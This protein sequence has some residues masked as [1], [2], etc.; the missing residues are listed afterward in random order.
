MLYSLSEQFLP[1]SG[2]SEDETSCLSLPSAPPPSRQRSTADEVH[3][4]RR[5]LRFLLCVLALGFAMSATAVVLELSYRYV[6]INDVA[7]RSG[8]Q[9]GERP[10]HG[11][12]IMAVPSNATT[13][14]PSST[15]LHA[16]YSLRKQSIRARRCG[17]VLYT[18]CTRP[19]RRY[20]YKRSEGLCTAATDDSAHVCSKGANR[21]ASMA[22]CRRSCLPGGPA[23][24]CQQSALFGA[25]ERYEAAAVVLQRHPLLRVELSARPVSGTGPAGVPVAQRVPQAVPRAA[26]PMPAARSHRALQRAPPAL[27]GVRRF[28]ARRRAGLLARRACVAAAVP[29]LARRQHVPFGK[30]LRKTVRT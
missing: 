12:G 8:H 3:L 13:G 5:S 11:A 24:R 21:F 17:A 15:A 27:P 18:Y 29:V 2:Q 14:Q 25:C 16:P 19:S 1:S 22:A 30:G 28:D 20:Y 23:R 26:A 10:D 9:G 4:K 7:S 6:N